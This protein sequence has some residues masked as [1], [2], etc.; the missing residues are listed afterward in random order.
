MQYLNLDT[1]LIYR[2]LSVALVIAFTLPRV[3]A[4]AF[5]VDTPLVNATG[6][7]ATAVATGFAP[8]VANFSF[9]AFASL[10]ADTN[11]NFLP[12]KFTSLHAT[13][14][15]LE[16][17]RQVGTGNFGKFTLPAKAFPDI[18][19]PLNF[20]YAVSNSSDQTCQYF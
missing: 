19:L 3:P 13:V 4:F 1:G 2:L 5:N 18:S 16:T 12:V 6:S 14:F 15:D 17:N 10:Q 8:S 11:S 9:P 20:T 7:W